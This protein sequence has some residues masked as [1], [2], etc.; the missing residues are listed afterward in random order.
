MK[1]IA[2]IQPAIE[3]MVAE[4]EQFIAGSPTGTNIEGLGISDTP[5]DASEEGRARQLLFFEVFE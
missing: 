2:Y 3:M 5:A 1:K 4:T